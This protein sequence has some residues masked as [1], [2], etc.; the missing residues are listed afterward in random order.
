M[1]IEAIYREHLF[2]LAEFLEPNQARRF[3]A[4]A[5]GN[6]DKRKK[7]FR[8]FFHDLKPKK[9]M[10]TLLDGAEGVPEII[11]SK[12]IKLGAPQKVYKLSASSEKIETDL[13]KAVEG[14]VGHQSGAIISCIPKKL[15]FWESDDLNYRYI[16][17]REGVK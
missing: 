11:C 17:H 4:L 3:V 10:A 6:D 13:L 7:L 14:V 15:A 8:M 16:L 2:G 9:S 12:L 1:E 5:N